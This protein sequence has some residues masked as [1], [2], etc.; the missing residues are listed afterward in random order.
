MRSGQIGKR[1]AC[2]FE[3]EG[4]VTTITKT[5]NSSRKK[6]GRGWGRG[7]EKYMR[8]QLCDAHYIQR[9]TLSHETQVMLSS[10]LHVGE[11]QRPDT[12]G[13]LPILTSTPLSTRVKAR[14]GVWTQDQLIQ[15]HAVHSTHADCLMGTMAWFFY[16]RYHADAPGPRKGITRKPGSPDCRVPLAEISP[17][18]LQ[19]GAN[20]PAKT[21]D[22]SQPG[23]SRG[24]WDLIF[25]FLWILQLRDARTIPHTWLV[26]AAAPHSCLDSYH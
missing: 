3:G 18:G 7:R 2:A 26:S 25:V 15:A 13:I 11:H 16:H 5:N 17:T 22:L 24:P 4:R 9:H 8:A 21:S 23:S 19:I 20:L 6:T 14:A 12:L 1:P 10:P